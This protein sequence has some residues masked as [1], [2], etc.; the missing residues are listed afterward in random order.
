[1]CAKWAK[2]DTSLCDACAKLYVKCR[3]CNVFYNRGTID[4]E[5]CS[6]CEADRY[7]TCGTCGKTVNI[8]EAVFKLQSCEECYTKNQYF[9]ADCGKSA[10]DPSPITGGKVLC[11][12]CADSDKY[13]YCSS[14][15]EYHEQEAI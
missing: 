9:C 11:A 13:Q 6:K 8:L 2:S 15:C 10:T 3:I 12:T 4:R 5:I 7:K 1:M 14:C